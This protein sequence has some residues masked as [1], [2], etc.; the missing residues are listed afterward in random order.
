[1]HIF[2]DTDC[3]LLMRSPAYIVEVVSW[4]GTV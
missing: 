2:P 4:V 3:V 1:M